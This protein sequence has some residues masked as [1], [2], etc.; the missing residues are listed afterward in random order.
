MFV[1]LLAAALAADSASAVNAKVPAVYKQDLKFGAVTLL[2][3]KLKAIV[4]TTWVAQST[5]K[6][7]YEPPESYFLGRESEFRIGVQCGP[8][9]KAVDDW[10]P[11]LEEAF[12]K[13]MTSWSWKKFREEK[14]L[15][16]RFMT[17]KAP[18]GV[19]QIV[20]VIFA[21]GG[22]KAFYC[23]ARLFPQGGGITAIDPALEKVIPAF[24]EACLA[25][26]K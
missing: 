8:G 11:V 12:F 2:E 25:M 13:E 5:P 9:C 4:P 14:G 19:V 23:K 20:R 15:T 24:E 21:P 7:A 1:I 6:G 18:N 3:E 10:E 26:K 22:D 17:A 16:H